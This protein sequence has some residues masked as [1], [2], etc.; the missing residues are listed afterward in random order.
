MAVL[1]SEQPGLDTFVEGNCR[2]DETLSGLARG[3]IL[4]PQGACIVCETPK[5][6][7]PQTSPQS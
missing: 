1:M 4:I 6:K 7:V 2:S 3:F 5:K